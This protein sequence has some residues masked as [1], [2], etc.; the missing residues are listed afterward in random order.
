MDLMRHVVKPAGLLG[1]VLCCAT[2]AWADLGFPDYVKFPPQIVLNPDQSLQNETVAEVEFQVDA[3]GT[4]KLVKGHRFAR[5]MT[6]KPSAGEP[7]PGYYN[8]TEARIYQ[9]MQATL[10]KSGW[11]MVKVN[12]NKSQWVMRLQVNGKQAWGEVKMDA[13]QAQVWLELIELADAAPG[14]AIPKP[15]ATPEKFTL[16]DDIPFLPPWPGSTRVHEGHST[17]PLDVAEPGK[18][19]E[20]QLV[21]QTYDARSYQ[22]AKTVSKLQF[23]GEYRE[24]LVKAGWTVLYPSSAAAVRD[25]NALAA[26]Y[27]QDGRDIWTRIGIDPAAML[28]IHMVD[29]SGT[30]LAATLNK[31]CHVPLYGV[32]FDFNKASLKP[33][34]DALLNK[35]GNLLKKTPALKVELDGHTD[36]VGGDDY[37]LKLS[38]ARAASVR[39]WLVQFGID[40]SRMAS[41][42][43]G[44]TRP[45]AD[46]GSDAGRAKNRRVELAK[47][48]CQ[49]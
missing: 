17:E 41:K 33:D 31:D 47:V 16:K 29:G 43:Y 13:P 11:Q 38:D 45:V 21:G 1:A 15:A 26:H 2:S 48:G 24:A 20:P 36:N 40:A 19:Q 5:W 35:V 28:T 4:P 46:N 44:K 10:S 27:T 39:N 6:Y 30:D 9:A 23:I 12:D 18:S 8:G 34:S 37:N 14:F 22:A 3:S 32:L 25:Y 49:R 7:A 42:G